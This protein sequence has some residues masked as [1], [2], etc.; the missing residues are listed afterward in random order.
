MLVPCWSLDLVTLGGNEAEWSARQ[1]RNTAVLGSSFAPTTT[2]ICFSV[3]PSSNPWS[4]WQMTTLLYPAS[5]GFY[6][7]FKNVCSRVLVNLL[8]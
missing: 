4:R 3:A 6:Y 2:W 8:D 1:A 5:L 7:L